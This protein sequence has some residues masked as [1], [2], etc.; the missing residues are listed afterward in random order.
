MA[1]LATKPRRHD[2]L[3]V[4]ESQNGHSQS[5]D[6]GINVWRILR[7]DAR[8]SPAQDYRRRTHSRELDS[9]HVARHDLRIHV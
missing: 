3:T 9:A 8:R 7:V 1:H 2:L 4:A 5:K 6:A